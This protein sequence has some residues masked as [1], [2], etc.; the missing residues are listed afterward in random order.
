M[1]LGKTSYSF[2]MNNNKGNISPILG[3]IE[4]LQNRLLY[5][6]FL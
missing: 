3:S 6:S 4:I 5:H 1:F 2:A